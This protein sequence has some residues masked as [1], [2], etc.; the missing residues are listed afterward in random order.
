MSDVPCFLAVKY[1]RDF[2]RFLTLIFFENVSPFLIYNDLKM[3]LKAGHV[4]SVRGLTSHDVR[5]WH[6]RDKINKLIMHRSSLLIILNTWFP[7]RKWY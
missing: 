7:V 4:T 3:M 6:T 1:K 5:T 2:K